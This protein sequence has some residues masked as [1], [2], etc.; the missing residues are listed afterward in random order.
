MFKQ[1]LKERVR[2]ELM[3]SSANIVTLDDLIKEAT[4]IDND[5]YELELKNRAFTALRHSRGKFKPTY[6]PNNQR[7]Q[8]N[9]Y[10]RTLG[11]YQARELESIDV[12]TIKHRK[13]CSS[14]KKPSY[15]NRKPSN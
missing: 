6:K 11:Y 2:T 3:R 7:P 12:D 8:E 13:F 10:P 5:L 15:S 1:E 4:R 9:F 14:Y